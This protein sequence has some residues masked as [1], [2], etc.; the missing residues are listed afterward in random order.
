LH[1]NG[2]E[3][4]RIV[5]PFFYFEIVLLAYSYIESP[6]LAARPVTAILLQPYHNLICAVRS[7]KAARTPAHFTAFEFVVE[8]GLLRERTR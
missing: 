7:I 4:I 8:G 1:T 6:A 5:T 2:Q 3:P